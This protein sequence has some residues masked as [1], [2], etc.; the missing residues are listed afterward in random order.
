MGSWQCPQLGASDSSQWPPPP[1]PPP[2]KCISLL[3]LGWT[4]SV[5][6]AG[7]NLRFKELTPAWPTPQGSQTAITQ[8]AV[9]FLKCAP[10]PEVW[11]GGWCVGGGPDLILEHMIIIEALASPSR[12]SPRVLLSS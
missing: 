6:Q 9:G 4:Y 12:S 11:G 10:P 5:R 1:V 2:I 7:F 8:Q 3:A